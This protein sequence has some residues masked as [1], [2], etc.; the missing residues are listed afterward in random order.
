MDVEQYIVLVN[1]VFFVIMGYSEEEIIGQKFN[2]L[3]LGIY[4]LFFFRK[5]FQVLDVDGFW[6]GEIWNK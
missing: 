1:F 6:C 2:V 3:L 4:L 5:M